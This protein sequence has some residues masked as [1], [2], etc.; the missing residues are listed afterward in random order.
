MERF[1]FFTFALLCCCGADER[2]ED[3]LQTTCTRES[4][5]PP[6]N[7]IPRFNDCTNPDWL[8]TLACTRGPEVPFDLI[9]QDEYNG[10]TV[11]VG[12]SLRCSDCYSYV[13]DSCG[14]SVCAK[15]GFTGRGDG[16][17]P[18]FRQTYPPA[19]V[20]WER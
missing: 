9:T 18:D 4:L 20:I 7:D 14:S 15:G 17:C 13:Y 16:R 3:S 8:L 1:A 10:S 19:V 2:P 11:Y 6:G 12:K 5:E